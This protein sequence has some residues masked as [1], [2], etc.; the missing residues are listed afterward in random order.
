METDHDYND[1]LIVLKKEEYK[2]NG[3]IELRFYSEDDEYDAIPAGK[4]Q[5]VVSG[6]RYVKKT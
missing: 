1:N 6:F 3:D 4:I 2:G 5:S